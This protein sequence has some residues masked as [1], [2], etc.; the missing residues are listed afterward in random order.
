[1][2]WGIARPTVAFR[3]QAPRCLPRGRLRSCQAPPMLTTMRGMLGSVAIALVGALMLQS[4]PAGERWQWPTDSTEVVRAFE[5]PPQPWAA[6]HRGIDIRTGPYA[7]VRAPAAG[8]IRFAGSI[9]DRGVLSI[10]HGDDVLS[11][12][13][14]VRPLV[15]EGEHVHAGQA[16]AVIEGVHSGC[17]HCLHFGVRI[18]GEYVDPLRM[19]VLERPV[20]LPIS[21]SGVGSSV[22]LAK[23][24]E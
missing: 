16:V 3:T 15:A 18:A 17:G 10:D 6:G 7:L 9:V 12:Y 8:T 1:M 22:G 5:Q 24:V 13:E 23:A 20:L 4:A 14:P 19:L 21:G 11:S 2:S